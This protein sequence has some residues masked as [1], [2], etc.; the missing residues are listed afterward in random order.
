MFLHNKDWHL[1][2]KTPLDLVFRP[3]Y[4]MGIPRQQQES[5]KSMKMPVARGPT[6]RHGF[7]LAYCERYQIVRVLTNHMARYSTDH[8]LVRCIVCFGEFGLGYRYTRYNNSV[9]LNHANQFFAYCKA[10]FYRRSFLP[11]VTGRSFSDCIEKLE[12]E[13][14]PYIM[15]VETRGHHVG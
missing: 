4:G 9:G 14:A 2:I 3:S 1:E 11:L 12:V 6:S 13:R 10:L 5:P 8:E 7:H 15:E